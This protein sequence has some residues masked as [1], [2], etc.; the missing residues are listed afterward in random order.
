MK[1]RE[2]ERAMFTDKEF[3]KELEIIKRSNWK[4]T[5]MKERYGFFE[6][7]HELV[8]SIEKD[9]PSKLIPVDL[10]SEDLHQEIIFGTNGVV[11]DKRL[12]TQI[13]NP[14]V[15]LLKYIFELQLEQSRLATADSRKCKSEKGR[16]NL[17]NYSESIFGDWDNFY[18]RENG[19]FMYQPLTNE[20][21]KVAKKFAY[22]LLRF[23]NETYGMDNYIG[24]ELSSIMLNDFAQ[25]NSDKRTEE[26]YKKMEENYKLYDK[27][28]EMQKKLFDYLD[29]HFMLEGMD[30]THFFSLFNTKLIEN[31][32][33]EFRVYL[34]REFARK[35]LKDYDKVEE[36]A[37]SIN[38]GSYEGTDL[39]IIGETAVPV[40][41]YGELG[42]VLDKIISIKTEN[43]YL[44]EIDNDD[45]KLEAMECLEY[46][47]EVR[48][49]EGYIQCNY[50]ANAFAFMEVKNTLIIHYYNVI[51]Q[52]IKNN[53][54]FN[55][56]KPV[57]TV[58]PFSKYEAFLKFTH[59][60][61]YEEVRKEQFASLKDEVMK[62]RGAK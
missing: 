59:G 19:E 7:F 55:T 26:N 4:N 53:N 54:V 62:K 48:D 11:V 13:R 50:L 61:T 22:D 27:E 14:Y 58:K 1:L 24:E 25:E 33:P 51:N 43:L 37:E 12:F 42:I 31:F 9:V 49:D 21:Y 36:L 23:M 47:R 17:V 32:E 57:L 38:L 15:M 16:K 40:D 30:D 2:I 20:S 5:K 3:V 6:K 52:A 44:D 34:Y 8:A 29:D 60:L 46:M 28:N 41:V 35:L 39:I 56:G 45:L 10:S 18:A